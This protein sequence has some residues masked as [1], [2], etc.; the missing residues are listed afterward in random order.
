[1]YN[2]TITKKHMDQI[3]EQYN[4]EAKKQLIYIETISDAFN[5]ECTR[6]KDQAELKISQLNQNDPS[7]KDQENKIKLQLKLDLKKV[8]DQYEKE[9]K[10]NFISG[11]K[12][13]ESIYA[14]KEKQKLLEIEREVL[15]I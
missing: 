6:L 15:Q 12:S 5:K 4:D 10:K 8:L 1:M 13:L 14:L 9:L 7:V 11:I 3:K 2:K